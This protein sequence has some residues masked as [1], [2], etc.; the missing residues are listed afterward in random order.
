MSAMG[1]GFCRMR[2]NV[3]GRNQDDHVKNIAFLM[4]QEGAWSR[5]P[6]FD[7]TFAYNPTGL[8]TARPQMTFN[9]RT[10]GFT[11]AHFRACAQFA[12]LKRGGE[13]DILAEVAAACE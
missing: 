9:G 8:W 12:G 10:H 3:V 13:T 1:E 2:G 4:D 11:R 6:A 5:S 7:V